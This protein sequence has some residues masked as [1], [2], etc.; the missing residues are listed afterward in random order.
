MDQSLSPVEQPAGVTRKSGLPPIAPDVV[1]QDH[2]D[3]F[4]NGVPA[5]GYDMLPIV[6]LGG[7]AGSIPALQRFFA[8]TP[9]DTGMAFVVVLH[10]SAEHGSI[11]DEVLARSTGMKVVQA[12]DG[13]EVEANKVYVI[14]AGY[15]LTANHGRLRLTTMEPERGKRVAIDLFFR[16]MADT[17]GPHAAAI[18]LSGADGDGALG[19]K[20]IKERGGLTIA[21]A[22]EEAEHPSMPRSA[23]DTGMV[24]WIL[25]A[26]EMPARLLAYRA[27]AAR[28]QLP[29]EEAPPTAADEDEQ[30]LREVL[31][32][33]RSRTGRDFSSY[34]RATVL[35]RI[36]R[37]MQVNATATMAEYLG[38]LRTHPSEAGA[39]H[40][41]LLISVTNFFRDRE[42]FEALEAEIPRIFAGKGAGDAVRVW[43]AGCATGEEAYSLAML[44]LEHA[45]RMDAPPAIQVFATDLAEDAI[46][47]A[48]DAFYPLVIQADVSE[49]RLRR[50]FTREA[51]GFRA[52][53][54][55][56]ECVLFA[57]HDL[58]RDV[59]FLRMDLFSCRN[60]LIYL[61][62]EA[63]A[64]VYTTAHYALRPGGLLFIGSSEALDEESGRWET[65]DQKHRVYRQRP[66]SLPEVPVPIG[67]GT[68]TRALEVQERA[69]GGPYIL[70]ASFAQQSAA[71]LHRTAAE[72][73]GRKVSWEE[74][75]FKL[76][77]RYAPPSLI[78]TRDYDIVHVSENAGRFLHFNSGQ[79]SV[80]LLKVVHPM[81]RVELRAA[82]FRA[83]QTSVPV[84]VF[85]LPVEIEKEMLAVDIRVAPA[86]EIAPDYLLVVFAIRETADSV[87]VQARQEAEPAVRHLERENED[88]KR[89]LR[90][91]VEQ[92]EAVVEEQKAGAEEL[93]AMNEELRSGGEELETSREELQSVNEEL[94]TVNQELK[95][96]V[97]DLAR[98][99]ED[100]A[101]LMAAS[102]VATIFL[103]RNLMT[104]RYTP[105]AV[106]LFRLIPTDL[107]RPLTDLRH[108]LH[109]PELQE[110]AEGV[111]RTQ[112][113][114][115]REVTDG[116]G[117]YLA[118]MLPYRA[119]QDPSS[120]VVLTLIDI[121][122]TRRAE[123][124]LRGSELRLRT[125]SD[126]VPQII[127]TNDAAGRA[128]YFNYRWYDYSGLSFEQSAGLG[129]QAIV[130][131]DDELVA[132]ARWVEAFT[133][134]EVFDTEYRLRASDGKYRWFIGRNV[135]MHDAEGQVTGW[136]GTA[137]DI[138]DLKEAAAALQ[139]SE[140]QFR[141]ALEDSPI[142]VMMHAEDGQ[143]LQLS[144]AW[145]ELTGYEAADI[146]TLQVWLEKA[147]GARAGAMHREIDAV[148]L[149]N[150]ARVDTEME[151]MTRRGE[152]RRW[153]FS[154]SAPG[155][156]RDG[157]RFI[158]TMAVD[159]TERQA[160]E[161][162][163]RDSEERVR[164]AVES[165]KMGT[166]EWDLQQQQVTWNELHFKLLGLAP[167]PNPLPAS[168]FFDHVHPADRAGLEEHIRRSMAEHAAYEATFRIV[169]DQG[170]ERWMN[171]YGRVTREKEGQAVQ[172]SGV[173]FDIT[174]RRTSEMS[175]RE[176]EERLRLIVENAR[177]YAI[178]SMDLER[179]ITSWNRG[180]AVILQHSH[181][182][183]IGQLADIIFTPEDR[184]QHAPE[185]EAQ[186]ALTAG[187]AADERW[188]LRKD[189][190]RFWGSGVMMAMH[191]A[192]GQA[193]GLVKIFRDHTAQLLATEALEKSQRELWE[194]LS[195]ADR[196]RGEAEAAGKAKDH[197]LAVLSHELRTPLTPV[198][199]A[200]QTLE[201]R[202]DLPERVQEALA[203]IRRN[204][205]IESRFVDELLDITKIERGKMELVRVPMDVH[206]AI[207]HAVEIS[208]PD[209]ETKA[210]QLTVALEAPAH[211]L[212]GD[213]SRLQQVVWN[214]LKNAS[215]FTPVGGEIRLQTR[216]EAGALVIEVSDRGIGLEPEAAARIFDPF[217]QADAAITREYGGL[218]LGLAIAK[219]SVLGHGGEIR[220]ESEGLGRGATF[221]VTLPL[222]MRAE[223]Q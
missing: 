20:R 152:V 19:L 170:E 107:G 149:G 28:L 165:A 49:E 38:F 155:A 14:P 11:L 151:V 133:A 87:E 60:L 46:A 178:F 187:R 33:L 4:D 208:R 9:A 89:R 176:S 80:N 97:D 130:H 147:F 57:V 177:E 174:D 90:D 206:E 45:G 169:T 141:R 172:M 30:A 18:V 26:A 202:K 159:I 183:A 189:G 59:P 102:G 82:L 136:F 216:N 39:L 88:L 192:Q 8:A 2:G 58:L 106:T 150:R 12:K 22:P 24:D 79:P 43:T 42:A 166:W 35:R 96:R 62:E 186:T 69:R 7:S 168:V 185:Q 108:R 99:N 188:H 92:Y 196:A 93:Q 16:T 213:F 64:R 17:Y 78:V 198:L 179:R 68:L 126:A 164:I 83:A 105:S 128:N 61:T 109:Y 210:Q 40:Q 175:L 201:R 117:W 116:H 47:S 222:A 157:R 184:A 156:L 218:G 77:E 70:A 104:T 37:R 29:A 191:D 41:D 13:Q 52:R 73:E 15:F 32:H 65:L 211:H 167:R 112:A 25:P 48:R 44:L 53:R 154:A 219:A 214:L 162:A 36:G 75:H 72:Q 220:V 145:T 199:M 21:Q 122:E 6:G 132:K 180:A 129:W 67:P 56:R 98:A 121:S 76:I 135:P 203:M 3:D 127:W 146:P 71:A 215:K 204:I 144:K 153:S 223:P 194:A 140:E 86:Q 114:M 119:A 139:E 113:P 197:F 118:Q 160:A 173:M 95:S 142:P 209:V 84:E 125:L 171:G 54:E 182:E 163:A 120:G 10:L 23:I 207:Q 85:R 81:L 148:Y 110:D 5:R 161:Q 123:Q 217:T 221:F 200:T 94:T 51:R 66:G 131:M 181:E 63:Q 34:K 111:L 103:D 124:A 31:A 143:V 50:F 190:S 195:E 158:V 101:S 1:E 137:T 193:I 91:T 212:N 27:H 138:E 205:L 115:K 100:L 74:L 55:L 134:G